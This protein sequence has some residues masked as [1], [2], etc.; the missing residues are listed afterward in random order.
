MRK[1]IR[2]TI[3]GSLLPLLLV[4]PVCAQRAQPAKNALSAP[5]SS[6]SPEQL[7]QLISPSVLVVE[8]SGINGKLQGSAVAVGP[9]VAATNCHVVAAVLKDSETAAALLDLPTKPQ[10]QATRTAGT[11]LRSPAE[12]PLSARSP[13]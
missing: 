12:G 9:N 10:T 1:A 3:L 2:L 5:S 11:R 13:I 6:L 7:F 8:S 4:L